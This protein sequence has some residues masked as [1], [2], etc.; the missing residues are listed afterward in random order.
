LLRSSTP[1]LGLVVVAKTGAIHSLTDLNG[2]RLAMADG[3]DMLSRDAVLRGLQ[4][5]HISSLRQHSH[6]SSNSFWDLRMGKADAAVVNNVS[7]QLLEPAMR[8][9]LRVVYQTEPL[10]PPAL[11]V[12]RNVPA[13]D[14]Q[15]LH[16]ALL[17]LAASKPVLINHALLGG[18]A[19]TELERDYGVLAKLPPGEV[20]SDAP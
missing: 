15:A 14:A 16:D 19:E 3:P 12:R 4:A 8:N 11:L 2:K 20:V 10:P 17:Q 18:L 6:T 5:Q 1:L 9:S 13:A 7:L